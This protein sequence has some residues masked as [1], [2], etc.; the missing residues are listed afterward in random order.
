MREQTLGTNL[1]M[2]FS[3]IYQGISITDQ[4]Y[5][6]GKLLAEAELL[7]DIRTMRA[8]RRESQLLTLLDPAQGNSLDQLFKVQVAGLPTRQDSLD[9]V[10][11]EEG[12]AENLADITVC[13]SG[14]AGQGS[15]VECFSL[16][17]FVMPAVG[18]R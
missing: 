12:T 8:C 1:S 5:V 10:W 14:I 15:D 2:E 17:H 13:Q 11:R 3:A 6:E 16:D 18:S 4:R 9:D 7:K